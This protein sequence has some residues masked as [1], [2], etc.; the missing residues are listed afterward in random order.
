MRSLPRKAHR[1]KWRTRIL[2]RLVLGIPIT[3]ILNGAVHDCN[4]F[5]HTIT[6]RVIRVTVVTLVSIIILII[7]V[8][9]IFPLPTAVNITLLIT[10]LMIANRN[11]LLIVIALQGQSESNDGFMTFL[12]G[13]EPEPTLL[14]LSWRLRTE[15]SATSFARRSGRWRW[16]L[17]EMCQRE[18]WRACG[19]DGLCCEDAGV[20]P[21]SSRSATRPDPLG[22]GE[23]GN[24]SRN[25]KAPSRARVRG[26]IS[27]RPTC[28]TSGRPTGCCRPKRDAPD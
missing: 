1:A 28:R 27:E 25:R 9:T 16:R 3:V 21:S 17:T 20:S 14:R 19:A 7:M 22:T 12:P 6:T 5:S 13:A 23:P 10:T 15:A 18:S 11:L 26:Q 4:T 2:T 24:R 8:A